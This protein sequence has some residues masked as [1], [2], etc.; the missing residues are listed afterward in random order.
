MTALHVDG[1]KAVII[2]KL[3]RLARDLTVQEAVAPDLQ[4]HALTLLSVAESD[5]QYR[6]GLSA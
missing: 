3:D 1:V 2:E 5:S 4:K 6:S